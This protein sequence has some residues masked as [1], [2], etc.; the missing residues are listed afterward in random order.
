MSNLE[1]IK[2]DLRGVASILKDKNSFVPKYQRSYAWKEENVTHFLQDIGTAIQNGASEYFLGSVVIS[3]KEEG[4]PEIV[5][6][7]Q[8]L[9]TTLIMLAAIRDHFYSLDTKEGKDRAQMIFN[10]Y[11]A[12]KDLDTLELI[13]KLNLNDSDHDYFLKKIIS[14]P[15]SEDRKIKPAKKSHERINKASIEAKKYVT[16]ISG[17]TKDPTKELVQWIIYLTEKAKVIAVRVPDESNAFTIFETLNDRGLALAVSD[18]LKNYLFYKSEDR[19]TEV[20]SQWVQVISTIEAAEDE[21]TVI[22][23]IRNYWSSKNGL[24][25]EK[26]LFDKIK[27]NVTS[28]SEAISLTSG[29][30]K[31]SVLY[32]AMITCD[33]NYWSVFS[34]SAKISMQTLNFFKM[35]Q[36]RPLILSVLE[37][38]NPKEATLSLKSL[39]NISV[40]FL[41]V[42]GLGGGAL[43]Q[44]YCD[45]A[46]KINNK[47]ISNSS[48]L[49]SFMKTSTPSDSE[50][51][52]AFQSATVS[53]NYLARYYLCALEM[54][55][56]GKDEPE[57]VPNSSNDVVTLEHILP[58]NPSKAW[59]HIDKD[60]AKTNY[61][62][63]GNLALLKKTLNSVIGNDG[64][65]AKK[66]SYKSSDFAL[67]SSISNFD[68]WGVNEIAKRQ[69]HLS[70]LAVKAWS[71]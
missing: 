2:I 9:A 22:N 7:Q 28:K 70:D 62:R 60:D 63:L 8:R 40:R 24:V 4:H 29:L 21:Q 39:V 13:P 20:Q 68:V 71:V 44:K 27:R 12:K 59:S 26:E 43:E 55:E 50:F 42:G 51:K 33:D 31:T 6:G 17:I 16:H 67:T 66:P 34:P 69:D 32:S 18:L 10:D 64:F 41:I 58:Q 54:I 46:L 61:K 23:F 3:E 49:L 38:F 65:E 45:G 57:F 14:D 35:I 53:K 30:C 19:V 48:Q 36:I 47:E 52:S 37:N 1:E 25:R 11:L 56:Q 5:D 15:D